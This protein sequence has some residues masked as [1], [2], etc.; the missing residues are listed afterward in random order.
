MPELFSPSVI[1]TIEYSGSGRPP[2]VRRP[3]VGRLERA[4]RWP[5]CRL[6][7]SPSTYV[8]MAGMGARAVDREL[9]GV[10]WTPLENVMIVTCSRA[11]KREN[12]P[13]RV[14]SSPV[15]AVSAC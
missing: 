13:V 12:R 8:R 11:R 5:C 10:S 2:A 6:S 3:A 4:C 1:S 7:R 15:A 14:W 9:D